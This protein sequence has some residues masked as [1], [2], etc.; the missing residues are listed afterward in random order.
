[1]AV[2]R[3]ITENGSITL[4][5]MEASDTPMRVYF[6]VAQGEIPEI[7]C[8]VQFAEEGG[9]ANAETLVCP[10][11]TT[12][13]GEH[14]YSSTYKPMVYLNLTGQG[15]TGDTETPTPSPSATLTPVSEEPFDLNQLSA[16]YDV[17]PS[18]SR[19]P[20]VLTGTIVEVNLEGGFKGIELDSGVKYV[21]LNIQSELLG[22]H[23]G[24]QISVSSAYINPNQVGIQM[25]GTYLYVV[26][27][28]FVT[29]GEICFD[30]F[31]TMELVVTGA[32]NQSTYLNGISVTSSIAGTFR[33]KATQGAGG[34]IPSVYLCALEDQ[35]TQFKITSTALSF[36]TTFMFESANGTIY[37]G[38]LDKTTLQ[39]GIN[40]F[41]YYSC[42]ALF[43]AESVELRDIYSPSQPLYEGLST[44]PLPGDHF[45]GIRFEN[46][47][48][49]ENSSFY[50]SAFASTSETTGSEGE[51]GGTGGYDSYEN[52]TPGGAPG[53]SGYAS[54]SYAI[55][56][57]KKLQ[58][59]TDQMLLDSVEHL[60]DGRSDN[61]F[62]GGT[63]TVGK[64]DDTFELE[65]LTDDNLG[66][67]YLNE[68]FRLVKHDIAGIVYPRFASAPVLAY[69]SGVESI[70]IFDHVAFNSWKSTDDLSA[71]FFLYS[72]STGGT[73]QVDYQ[74]SFNI[75]SI[76]GS[77][78]SSINELEIPVDLNTGNTSNV[79]SVTV[80]PTATAN[81]AT[82]NLY[83]DEVI[84]IS[85][86][87]VYLVSFRNSV[88]DSDFQNGGL[89]I[90]LT[91]E[92]VR[93]RI[94]L[95]SGGV[96]HVGHLL[97]PVGTGMNYLDSFSS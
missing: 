9:L 47:S 52:Y 8:E 17:L 45:V 57:H 87:V 23:V 43:T 11:V 92:V 15:P 71:T 13:N 18:Y 30:D 63:P 54:H 86:P 67:D 21:P 64:L 66:L 34:A 14:Y 22:L 85:T 81:S 49:N 73:G 60:F 28:E 76:S 27:Y 70:G 93:P 44:H 32:D 53:G 2:E 83:Y 97:H 74:Q 7:S 35:T 90:T 95:V 59:V 19:Q 25:W 55:V 80:K 12:I 4:G 5:Q 78:T 82:F 6:V 24:K 29:S 16:D 39:S 20:V 91:S 75:D 56:V 40:T 3:F 79:S 10:Y 94:E 84:N 69:E 65:L 26:E 42:D 88:D 37:K 89:K 33:F 58:G 48:V 50:E 51:T 41:S 46:F 62:A 1:M 72:T 36:D 38:S 68:N 31:G 61:H 77:I 96:T